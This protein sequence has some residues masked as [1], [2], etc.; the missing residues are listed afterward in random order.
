[1][2]TNFTLS[3]DPSDVLGVSRDASIEQI[4][5]AYR[6]KTK[7]YHPDA[8]GE[9]WAF[10][11]LVQAYEVMCTTRVVRAAHREFNS[12]QATPPPAAGPAPRSR[13]RPESSGTEW[14]RPGFEEPAADPSLVVDVEKMTVLFEA[15]HVW[16]ITDRASDN[17]FLSC[18]LNITWPDADLRVPPTTIEDAD[19]ILVSLG[20]VFDALSVQS[21]AVSSRSSVVEGRFAG[22]VSYSSAE[23]ASAAFNLLRQLLHGSGL[24]VKRWSRDLVIPRQWR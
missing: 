6:S 3:I 12:A 5:E 14:V 24:S 8:G 11:I 16:L 15:D 23:R 22:W 9:D 20:E 17:R 10:R 13:P 7:K 1:L 2:S 4:R 18:C 21:R 19:R